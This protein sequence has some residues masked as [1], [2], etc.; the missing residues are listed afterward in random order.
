MYKSDQYQDLVTR[1]KSHS[2]L[3][4][5]L[6]PSEIQ[7][8]KYDSDHLGPWS[9]WQCS[10]DADVLVVGQ[11][12]GDLPY[13]VRN[14]GVDDPNEATCRNLR[15]LAL[16]AGW[17]LGSP[18]TP[19]P[20]RLFFTNAVLGIRA[21][22]GKSGAVPDAWI[23]DSLPFLQGIIEIV[24]PKAIVTLGAAA[25]KACRFALV[26]TGRSAQVP[27][28][29]TMGT[30]HAMGPIRL[31]GKPLWLPLYHCSPLGLVNRSIALQG[32]DWRTLC[33]HLA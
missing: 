15:S 29:S 13:F 24:Q 22:N 19:K 21:A 12:W 31:P 20:Q 32:E 3:S 28:S 6:N 9:R 18:V 11:D 7:G 30:L 4:G 2:F 33:H 8:G 5:L 14:R 26:G 1:R 10:L 27:A 25:A 23:H 16:N 17:D